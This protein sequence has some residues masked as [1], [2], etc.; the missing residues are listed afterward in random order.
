MPSR[1]LGAVLVYAEN[2]KEVSFLIN[3]LALR[4]S[5]R[6][7]RYDGENADHQRD[8]ASERPT[9]SDPT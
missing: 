3:Q 6:L 9:E 5:R 7:D 2:I 4:D 1:I 8:N